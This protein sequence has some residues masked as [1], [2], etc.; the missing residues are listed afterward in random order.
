LT[1]IR[2]Y[3]SA[4]EPDQH[5]AN[6]ARFEEWQ[7]FCRFPLVWLGLADPCE[8]RRFIEQTDPVRENLQAL[9][10]AWH[11]EFGN[12][13]VTAARAIMVCTGAHS[14][15][16]VATG[17]TAAFLREAMMAVA[18][19]N[20]GVN[21]RRLG[22]FIAR[23]ERRIEGGLRFVRAGTA[24][25]TTLWQ[26]TPEGFPGFQGF[27][28]DPSREGTHKETRSRG[29][30]NGDLKEKEGLERNPQ[31]PRNPVLREVEL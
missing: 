25:N 20:G 14:W 4:G 2:A 8:S 17:T 1:I 5:V 27:D 7:R 28:S 16:G 24:E 19:E 26:V 10:S 13:P 22:R 6:F 30:G 15:A 12:R 29:E 11:D 31:N 3:L 9:L 21:A 18:G 23:H